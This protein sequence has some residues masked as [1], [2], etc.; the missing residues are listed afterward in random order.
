MKY[1]KWQYWYESQFSNFSVTERNEP[2]SDAPDRNP[3]FFMIIHPEMKTN[4]QK[5]GDIC[6]INIIEDGI[7]RR[8]EDYD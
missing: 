2:H 8:K 4:F 1:L 5:Y 3:D 6:Y 7:I